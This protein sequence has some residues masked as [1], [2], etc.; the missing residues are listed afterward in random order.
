MFTAVD[1]C[2]LP[3][4]SD[5]RHT[6]LLTAVDS[7]YY[8]SQLK[9]HTLLF[10]AVDRCILPFPSDNRH[11]RLLTAVDSVPFSIN[12]HTLLFTAVD[13]RI[14]QFPSFNKHTQLLNAVDWRIYYHFLR[15]SAFFFLSF[16]FFFWGGGVGGAG[17]GGGGAGTVGVSEGCGYVSRTILSRL[18]S[19]VTRPSCRGESQHCFFFPFLSVLRLP[20]HPQP[21]QLHPLS[22]PPTPPHS[23]PH[24]P[25]PPPTTRETTMCFV[26]IASLSVLRH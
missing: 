22:P 15:P 24:P 23:P 12:R 4:S 21:L 13:S 5:N 6:R 8:R 7:V 10:T 20:P 19:S 26:Q 16:H 2:I 3:F 9:G 18:L 11:T 17:G 14:P 1:R 25:P